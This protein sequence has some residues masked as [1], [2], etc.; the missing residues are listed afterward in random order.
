MGVLNKKMSLSVRRRVKKKFCYSEKPLIVGITWF[1]F[2]K[3]PTVYSVLWAGGFI[4]AK[5][6][7]E[8]SVLSLLHST[9][10]ATLPQ[11]RK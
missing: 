1:D 4:K 7:S 3:S 2:R 6:A 8:S 9:S 5:L 11:I 10:T